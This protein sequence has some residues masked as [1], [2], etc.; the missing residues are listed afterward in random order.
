VLH[1]SKL[2]GYL[3]MSQKQFADPTRAIRKHFIQE[4]EIANNM[5]S[6]PIFRPQIDVIVEFLR[7]LTVRVLPFDELASFK[8]ECFTDFSYTDSKGLSELR[9]LQLYIACFQ[10]E[11]IWQYVWKSF[12]NV[13]SHQVLKTVSN[14]KRT[15][16]Y[17]ID[18]VAEIC[19]K[20]DESSHK[21]VYDVT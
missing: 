17:A 2:L 7:L 18:I 20:D 8:A 14:F 12:C 13:L 19:M 15:H 9:L 1:K 11:D 16:T 10:S 3:L 6:Q 4:P 5:L 21:L